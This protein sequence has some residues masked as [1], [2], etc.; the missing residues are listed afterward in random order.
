MYKCC[1]ELDIE[2]PSTLR[3]HSIDTWE[4]IEDRFPGKDKTRHV[5]R[6]EH[7]EFWDLSIKKYTSPR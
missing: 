1:Y 4:S 5:N 6:K 7:P 2:I 3:Q